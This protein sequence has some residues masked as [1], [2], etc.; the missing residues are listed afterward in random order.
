MKTEGMLYITVFVDLVTEVQITIILGLCFT[1]AKVIVQNFS[2]R[3][4][5]V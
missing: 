2:L 4:G 5:H 1:V 3:L